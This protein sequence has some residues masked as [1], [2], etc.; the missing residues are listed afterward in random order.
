M[1]V[2]LSLRNICCR[3]GHYLP[4]SCLPS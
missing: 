2:T 1:K 4:C 3:S